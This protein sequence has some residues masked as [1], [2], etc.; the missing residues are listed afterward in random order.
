LFVDSRKDNVLQAS[1]AG[2]QLTT[3]PGPVVI[4]PSRRLLRERG[5][6]LDA[7]LELAEALPADAYRRGTGD[8]LA[9]STQR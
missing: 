7:V 6:I 5:K 4:S 9:A 3:V 8:D 2:A 1:G